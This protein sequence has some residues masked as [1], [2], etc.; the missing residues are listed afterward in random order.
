[1]SQRGAPSF[2]PKVWMLVAAAAAG[3]AA[4]Y[5]QFHVRGASR[6]VAMETGRRRRH[7]GRGRRT[8]AMEAIN[9]DGVAMLD[10][11]DEHDPLVVPMAARLPGSDA[12]YEALPDLSA[13]SQKL[14]GQYLP[15]MRTRNSSFG[16]QGGAVGTPNLVTRAVQDSTPMPTAALMPASHSSLHADHP[17]PPSMISPPVLTKCYT[18]FE[19]N[20]TRQCGVDVAAGGTWPEPMYVHGQ[21]KC[22]RHVAPIAPF[23][24]TEIQRRSNAAAL[25][26]GYLHL[27]ND[28]L[29]QTLTR[30]E[31][32]PADTAGVML[33]GME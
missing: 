26:G 14:T 20:C 18:P 17:T 2:K 4:Y 31:D 16:M 19:D 23:N 12:T 28:A 5:Y 30:V 15:N 7:P 32:L 24:A 8:V 21:S 1:M 29:S 13:G 3:A 9:G 6:A 33:P 25:N 10:T 22:E 11:S 27:S